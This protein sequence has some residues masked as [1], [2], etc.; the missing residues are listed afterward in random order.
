MF[1][2]NCLRLE[3]DGSK[4]MLSKD[5]SW[6]MDRYRNLLYRVA[7][8]IDKYIR[9]EYNEMKQQILLHLYIHIYRTL[10]KLSYTY[11]F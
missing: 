7:P 5:E 1:S 10:E 8:D 6:R 9:G 4:Y 2:G 11:I 3:E